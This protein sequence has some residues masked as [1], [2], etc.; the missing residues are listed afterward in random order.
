MAGGGGRERR[1]IANRKRKQARPAAG[2]WGWV[3][4]H[5]VG[6][7]IGAALAASLTAWL[8]VF[9]GSATGDILP[10]GADAFCA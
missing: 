8:G 2:S 10:S 5:I 4:K 6:S 1:A 9:F 7:I 3:R